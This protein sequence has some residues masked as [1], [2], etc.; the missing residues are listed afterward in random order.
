MASQI[1]PNNI[2]GTYPIA[3]QDNNS[4]GFRDNFTNIK[5][6]F[7][8]A[9]DE[10]NTLQTNGAVLNGPNNFNDNLIYAATVQD[11]SATKAIVTTTSGSV[12]INYSAGHY[13]TINTTGS[14][15]LAFTSWPAT[16]SYGWVRLQINITNTAYTVTL[17]SAVSLGT[18]NLQGYNSSTR[19]ITFGATGYYELEFTTSNAGSTITVHDCTRNMDPIFLPSAQDLDNGAA[20][21]LTTTASYFATLTGETATLAD[22]TEG[23]IKTLI[24]SGYLGSMVITVASAGWNSGAS[25]TI[26]FNALGEGCTLQ[27]INSNWY[28]IGNNGAAFA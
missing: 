28:C 8:Y 26:T 9:E 20:V 12:S 22:G 3:G 4:Q 2:D 24:M 11:L 5:L 17:P 18:S 7:Q 14:I 21:S 13:Q 25:G 6:N 16:G 27:F 1:N 19:A 15:S 10:I 23:Q